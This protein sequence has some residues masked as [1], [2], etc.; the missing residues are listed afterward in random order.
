MSAKPKDMDLPPGKTCGDCQHMG[1][2][3]WLIQQKPQATECDWS[4]SRFLER[5][6]SDTE[7]SP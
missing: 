1:R 6:D 2:C 4:P 3:E 7:P 5:R